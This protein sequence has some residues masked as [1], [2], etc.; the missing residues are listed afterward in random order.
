MFYIEYTFFRVQ[1]LQLEVPGKTNIENAIAAMA[2]SCV[3]G[4]TPDKLIG[5]LPRMRGV[6]R[7][8]DVQY[9]SEKVV[10]ID[11]YAHHP[12]ELDAVI[13][14]LRDWFPGK[15]LPLYF[16]PTCFPVHAILQQNLPKACQRSMS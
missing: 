15:R 2:V 9:Q 8:F 16:N 4:A 5:A 1:N 12:R 6:V 13:S 7:R 10:Y 11:D 14:S 3:L